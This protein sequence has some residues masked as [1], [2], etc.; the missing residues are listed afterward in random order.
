MQHFTVAKDKI[1]RLGGLDNT[2][3]GISSEHA[4]CFKHQQPRLVAFWLGIHSKLVMELLKLKLKRPPMTIF[5][6][7]FCQCGG[8]VNIIDPIP[9]QMRGIT[10]GIPHKI[11]KELGWAAAASKT[12]IWFLDI[13]IMPQEQ[14]KPSWGLL[15]RVPGPQ[16]EATQALGF[17]RTKV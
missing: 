7:M 6:L 8:I 5:K 9:R 12:Q 17:Q 10:T 4:D 3:K 13:I 2:I 11:E 1:G 14:L 15:S 16:T